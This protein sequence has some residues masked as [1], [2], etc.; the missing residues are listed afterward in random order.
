M[1]TKFEMSEEAKKILDFLQTTSPGSKFSYDFLRHL[2]GLNDIDRLC[3]RFYTAA[4]RA[5]AQWQMRF[6]AERGVGYIRLDESGKNTEVS[7]RIGRTHRGVKRAARYHGAV[8]FK[9]LDQLGQ[10]ENAVNGMQLQEMK[11]AAS[12]RRRN[13]IATKEAPTVLPSNVVTQTVDM[14]KKKRV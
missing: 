13:I 12:R 11:R 3:S 2:T 6:A 14:F 10:L 4:R 7:R 1:A 9:Q 8:D 5:F